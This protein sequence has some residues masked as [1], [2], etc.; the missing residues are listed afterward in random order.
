MLALRCHHRK[1]RSSTPDRQRQY[2]MIQ[3]EYLI[4]S[5]S[6]FEPAKSAQG[7]SASV[8]VLNREG[9][10]GWEAVGMTPLSD[11]SFAVLMKRPVARPSNG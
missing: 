6:Q 10:D 11:G 2:A 3:W 5:L 7:A 9:V 8:S 1:R 4:I